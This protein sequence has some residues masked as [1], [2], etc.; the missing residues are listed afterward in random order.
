MRAGLVIHVRHPGA[1]TRKIR[2]DE[3]GDLFRSQHFSGRHPG[4][5]FP[6]GRNGSHRREILSREG[7]FRA[8]RHDGRNALSWTLRMGRHSFKYLVSW[9][10]CCEKVTRKKKV[11]KIQSKQTNKW[12]IFK[13]F[14]YVVDT[15][16]HTHTCPWTNVINLNKNDLSIWNRR[17]RYAQKNE[18]FHFRCNFTLWEFRLKLSYENI[19]KK[20]AMPL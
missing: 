16:T 20:W 7:A 9:N 4:Q 15:H 2:P 3:R 13:G 12:Q 14:S 18:M 10:H 8:F 17:R 6:W 1:T 11:I 5:T 19:F